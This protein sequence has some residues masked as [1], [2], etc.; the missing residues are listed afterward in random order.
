MAPVSG[1]IGKPAAQARSHGPEGGAQGSRRPGRVKTGFG[2]KMS[3]SRKGG[4]RPVCLLT[5]IRL[6][7]GEGVPWPGCDPEGHWTVTSN[8]ICE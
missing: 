8:E 3:Y 6:R 7:F 4:P 5:E 2:M 1:Q